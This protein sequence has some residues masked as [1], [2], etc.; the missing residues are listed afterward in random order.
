M[1]LLKNNFRFFLIFLLFLNSTASSSELAFSKN[2]RT[3]DTQHGSLLIKALA[4]S[5]LSL[6]E[7][8]DSLPCNPAMTTKNSKPNLKIQLQASNGYGNL[9]K[10]RRLLSGEIDQSILNDLLGDQKVLQLDSSADLMFVS[11][12]LNSRFSPFS[13]KYFSVARN[14]ANP[15]IELLAV[16]EQDLTLQTGYT[17]EN[18]DFGI[19]IRKVDWKF[20]KQRFKLLAVTTTQGLDSLK[21]KKQA[22]YIVQPAMNYNLPF[23]WSPRISLMYANMGSTN[24]TYDEFKHPTEIQFGFGLSAPV[25]VGK[26]DLLFDYK[27][28]SFDETDKEKMHFGVLYKY[29]AM[30]LAGGI[31]NNGMSLGVFNMLEQVNAGI[32]FST[33]RLPWKEDEFY[34]QTVYVQIGWQL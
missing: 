20:I 10:T 16:E 9:S 13:V 7:V 34:A 15:D 3:F 30:S 24:E 4:Y 31:D 12:Y 28:L 8:Q 11:K 25:P 22:A 19:E 18:F 27:S 33:T 14:D 32:L 2:S 26:L 21:P 17:Y 1:K 6:Y 23:P 29:G 5:C